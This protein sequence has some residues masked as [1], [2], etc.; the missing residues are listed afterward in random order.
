MTEANVIESQIRSVLLDHARLVG[1]PLSLAPEKDL[2]QFGMTSL[3]SVNVMLALED[4]FDVEF[5]DHMLNKRVFGSIATI[6]E[7]ILALTVTA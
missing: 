3:A 6:R 1:D 5:P 2:Y 7:A 4:A